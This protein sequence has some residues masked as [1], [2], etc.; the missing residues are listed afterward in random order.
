MS[1]NVS[2][3]PAVYLVAIEDIAQSPLIR[4]Q[5]IALLKAMAAQGAPCPL[6]L[7]ALYPMLNWWRH[8]GRLVTL[9]A[10]L[11]ES[12]IAFHAWPIAFL[13]RYFYM[14]RP[15]L[16]LY[17][18]QAWLAAL[19][20]TASLRPVIIHCRSY[21]ATLVGA[22][23]KRLIGARLVFDTRALY[24]E[25]GATLAEGG[26]S[27][28]LD[29]TAF[30][31]WKQIEAGLCREADATTVVSRPSAV[32][33]AEQYPDIVNRLIVAPTCTPVPS[34]EQ[35]DVWRNETRLKLGLTNKLVVAYAASWFE[36]QPTLGLFRQLLEACPQANW[37]FL[38][39]VSSRAQGQHQSAFE[40]FTALV[41]RELGPHTGCTVIAAAQTTVLQYLAGADLGA[42][43][44]GASE[45]SQADPRYVLAAKTR[46]SVKFTEYLAAGLPVLTSR[47]AGA[48]ADIVRE[49]DLGVVYDEASDA[50][51]A[52]WLSRW[53]EARADFSARA[54]QYAHE[55]FA[56]DSLARRYLNLYTR[57][58]G[59]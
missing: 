13:T 2:A 4:G 42:Q 12:G 56:L 21:P 47:W 3:R 36:P 26:K 45:R 1:A 18:I 59:S 23:V 25:E 46:L 29:P 24:P 48:A 11:A 50:Q 20:I 52:A 19:T 49:H 43:P 9:R 6:A 35:L 16:A 37:H 58:L 7:V 41:P 33:L 27:V 30:R 38:L 40:S 5:V 55:H 10:E 39:L 14:P 51:L 31:V 15:W 22:L 32:I 44:V 53:Q 54:W 34:V 17:R 8:R 57:L 28:L